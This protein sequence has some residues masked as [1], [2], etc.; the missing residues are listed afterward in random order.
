MGIVV[1]SLELLQGRNLQGAIVFKIRYGVVDY[2]RG[3]LLVKVEDEI[4]AFG[5]QQRQLPVP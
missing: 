2:G 3:A 1:F 4:T 5:G